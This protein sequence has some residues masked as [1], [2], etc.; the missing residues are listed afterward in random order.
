M[1]Y[2]FIQ[3]IAQIKKKMNLQNTFANAIIIK[4]INIYIYKNACILKAF[5]LFFP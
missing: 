2:F 5:A 4:I 3:F 1:Y